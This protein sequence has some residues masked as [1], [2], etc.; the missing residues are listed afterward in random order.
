MTASTNTPVGAD[1][2]VLV[3]SGCAGPRVVCCGRCVAWLLGPGPAPG[4]RATTLSCGELAK[5]GGWPRGGILC[6]RGV[7]M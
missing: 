6:Y 2:A 4:S 1:W 7:R 3:L 5:P